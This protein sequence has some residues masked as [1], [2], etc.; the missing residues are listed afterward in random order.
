MTHPTPHE[1]ASLPN[2]DKERDAFEAAARSNR[3]ALYV[4]VRFANG[5]VPEGMTRYYLDTK[6]EA[7]WQLWQAR[8]T[9]APATS[10][11]PVKA[12]IVREMVN[13]LRDIAIEFHGAQ[14][15]RERIA[16]AVGKVWPAVEQ[17]TGSAGSGE[18]ALE[19]LLGEYWSIAYSEGSTG[20]SRGD[21]ANEVLHKIRAAVAA[22]QPLQAVPEGSK[23]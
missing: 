11:E 15:L 17:P 3:Y 13:E 10:A 22:L 14:Q 9:I 1:A 7:A 20:V 16:H 18:Q 12:H 21:D 5:A 23:T 8:A 2:L 6:T 19:E 4:F